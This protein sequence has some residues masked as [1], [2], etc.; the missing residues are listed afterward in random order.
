MGAPDANGIYQYD[1]TDNAATVSGLLNK[2]GASVSTVVT[3]LKS[4]LTNLETGAA[5]PTVYVAANATARDTHWGT[6]AS[7]STRRALQDKGAI[8]I[9][10]DAGITEQYFAG[11]TDGGT[12]TGGA[13]EAGWYPI[14]QD[15]LTELAISSNVPTSAS[16]ATLSW[17]S[18][19]FLHAGMWT[20]GAPTKL[21]LPYHGLWDVDGVSA[22][23]GG[24][25]GILRTGFAYGGVVD[26]KTQQN[27]AGLSGQT[28]PFERPRGLIEV[29]AAQIAALTNYVEFQHSANGSFSLL[30][31]NTKMAARYLGRRRA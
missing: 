15:I 21:F 23:T 25:A 22:T 8:T 31:A 18:A 3:S 14:S 20:S 13:I 12:N 5:N 16:T 26:T 6:P 7:A 29:T 17:S 2:L 11:L 30:A 4:R 1:E 27:G 28:D 19:R 10:L 9:R 24:S